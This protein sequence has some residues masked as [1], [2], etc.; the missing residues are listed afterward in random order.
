MIRLQ[1]YLLETS[2]SMFGEAIRKG[3]TSQGT[4]ECITLPASP[5]G[6]KVV[7]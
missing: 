7:I 1:E 4:G 2:G 3:N 6:I 5:S